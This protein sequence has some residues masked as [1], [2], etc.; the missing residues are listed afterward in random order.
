MKDIYILHENEEWLVPLRAEFDKRNVTFKE[1][2]LNE[3]SVAY[4][5][6]PAPGVYYNRMS[7]SSH[8]RGHRFAPEL[9]RMALTW[10][11]REQSDAVRVL[12]GTPALYLEVCKLSQYA[13]LEK[14]GLK[15]PQTR[16]VVGREQI[17]PAAQD[18]NHWPLILKPNRGGKGLGVVKMDSAAQL[19]SY[20]NGSDYAEPLDGIWL[21][22]EYI[23]P[24][25]PHIT[26]CEFV[27]QQFVYAV[28]VDTTG[29]FE[30][31]PADVCAVGEDF[32]PTGTATPAK[33][34]ITDVYNDHPVL[35]QLQTFMRQAQVDVAGI[36]MIEDKQGRLFVYDVNTNTN[37][38]AEAE[39]V[40]GGEV[41]GMGALAD[42][43]ISQARD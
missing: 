29:G 5:K 32:C 22:Q 13:A 42:Y 40:A 38:N 28:Q 19:Q 2:F 36:E 8:T 9:T 33:F 27:G 25:N 34:Q 1:W 18:F 11:E 43:L 6:E 14:A 21:L 10:L 37:Y 26:R 41:T 7:A 17:L 3:G 16:A 30:L 20:I 31:C 15:T 23:E 12:N 24:A 4:D 35:K 39:Q